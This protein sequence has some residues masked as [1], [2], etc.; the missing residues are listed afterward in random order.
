MDAAKTPSRGQGRTIALAF[1]GAALVLGLA[2]ATNPDRGQPMRMPGYLKA[3]AAHAATLDSVRPLGGPTEIR[4]SPIGAAADSQPTPAPGHPDP[5]TADSAAQRAPG[6]PGSAEFWNRVSRAGYG[7]S[8][9]I[10]IT[11]DGARPGSTIVLTC[12]AE[13]AACPPPPHGEGFRIVYRDREG[14]T[15]KSDVERRQGWR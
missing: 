3:R 9:S 15:F 7:A 4:N 5:E 10:E 6:L 14:G 11:P 13:L 8:L 12:R 1:G 2:A